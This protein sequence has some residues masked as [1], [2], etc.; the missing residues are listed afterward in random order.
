MRNP[1]DISDVAG[2]VAGIVAVIIVIV[3][4]V[5]M[6][7][8]I[9][10]RILKKMKKKV[11]SSFLNVTSMFYTNIILLQDD[12]P[13]VDPTQSI[14]NI[15]RGH[16]DQSEEYGNSTGSNTPQPVVATK[17][18]EHNDASVSSGNGVNH[19]ATAVDKVDIGPTQVS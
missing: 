11:M 5:I 13:P 8:V 17:P 1:F 7:V 4:C 3:V 14:T 18:K 10:R 12:D 9:I 19:N 15:K 6:T 16:A 2:I